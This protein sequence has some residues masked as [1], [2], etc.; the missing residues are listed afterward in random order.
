MLP[1]IIYRIKKLI[2]KIEKEGDPTGR[3]KN[4]YK[5]LLEELGI[6]V[7]VLK[8][9]DVSPVQPETRGAKLVIANHPYPP[10]DG[11]VVMSWT[12]DHL[13]DFWMVMNANNAFLKIFP[14]KIGDVINLESSEGVLGRRNVER[15]I[16]TRFAALRKI[17]RCLTAGETVV[18]LPAGAG[19][20]AK[21]WGDEITDPDWSTSVGLIIRKLNKLG[22]EL[23]I[24]PLYFQGHMG[25]DKNSQIYQHA[26]IDEPSRLPQALQYALFNRPDSVTLRVGRLVKG[27]DLQKLDDAQVVSELRR[28]VYQMQDVRLYARKSK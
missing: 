2:R 14:D 20:K 27:S 28:R 21:V 25:N 6:E 3:L 26:I 5:F 4:P 17:I 10:I 16:A 12:K 8:T 15:A 23:Y 13:G 1:L 7:N 11:V 22:I 19:S 24:Y 9:N 18:I